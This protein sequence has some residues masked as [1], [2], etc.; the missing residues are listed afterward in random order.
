MQDFSEG[1]VRGSL[2]RFIQEGFKS[3]GSLICFQ[4]MKG[5]VR[6]SNNANKQ[7]TQN[8]RNFSLGSKRPLLNILS[9]CQPFINA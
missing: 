3:L 8:K 4:L 2:V 7:S 5:F 1:D 9:V 6:I